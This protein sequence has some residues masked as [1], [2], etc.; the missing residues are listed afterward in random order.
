MHCSV[1]PPGRGDLHCFCRFAIGAAL[2]CLLQKPSQTTQRPVRLHSRTDPPDESFPW[3]RI[4]FLGQLTAAVESSRFRPWIR[5]M[6]W[7]GIGLVKVRQGRQPRCRAIH[8]GHVFEDIFSHL[9]GPFRR[10]SWDYFLF[11]ENPHPLSSFPCL[12]LPISHPSHRIFTLFS[13][14]SPFQSSSRLG[15]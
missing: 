5:G 4:L 1:R 9:Y 8:G 11:F 15:S 3:P 13:L 7:H 6:A 10:L 12:L 2:G 14:S